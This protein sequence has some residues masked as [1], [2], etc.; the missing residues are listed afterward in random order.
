MK[1]NIILIVDNELYIFLCIFNNNNYI[2]L[3]KY[4]LDLMLYIN[5]K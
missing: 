2:I 4:R 1:A 5:L 3:I